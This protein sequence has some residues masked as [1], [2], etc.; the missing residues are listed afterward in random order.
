LIKKVKE[1]KVQPNVASRLAQYLIVNNPLYSNCTL[2]YSSLESFLKDG[3]L[4]SSIAYIDD[5]NDSIEQNL[6]TMCE[7]TVA[8]PAD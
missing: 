3:P 7:S 1:A 2:D 6:Q 5:G 8:L 4:R